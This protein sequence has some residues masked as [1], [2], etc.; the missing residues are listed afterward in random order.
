MPHRKP[1][2]QTLPHLPSKVGEKVQQLLIPGRAK[3]GGKN[4][5]ALTVHRNMTNTLARIQIVVQGHIMGEAIMNAQTLEQFIEACQ[6]HL[7]KLKEGP[8]PVDAASII[9]E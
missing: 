5:T 6:H 1:P 2:H 7:S 3:A 4:R 8:L 9:K